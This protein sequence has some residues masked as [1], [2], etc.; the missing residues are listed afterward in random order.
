[1]PINRLLASATLG[2]SLLIAIAAGPSVAGATPRPSVAAPPSFPNAPS[3]QQGARWLASQLTSGGFVASSTPGQPDLVATANTVLALASAGVD[4]PAA[5]AALVYLETHINQYVTVSGSD[6]PGQL[7]ILILDA[8][9]LGIDP[10]SFGG[11]DLVARLLATEQLSGPNAGLFGIQD[12]SF[13]GAFR[14]GLSLAALAAAGVTGQTLAD[15]WLTGQQCPDG[16]WTSLITL[17]NPCS[18]DPASFSGPDTNSTALAIQGLEAQHALDPTHAASA[19]AFLGGGQDSDGGWSFFP[20]TVTTPGSTDPDSTAL[21]VQALVALGQSPL[22]SQ[23]AKGSSTPVSSLLGFQIGSGA[24]SGAF[25]FTGSTT[26]N[27]LATYQAVPALAG[28]A[29]PLVAN[30]GGKGYW[31]ASSDGGIFNYGNAAFLGSHGSSPLNK[32]IVGL[33]ATPDGKGYWLAAS[34]GGIFNYGNA[35]FAGSH[36]GSPLNKPIVGMA[37]TPDG[38]GYWLVASDGG[39]FAY[40]D[41]AFQGSHGGSPLNKPIVGMAA[42]PSGLGYWLVAS[43]GGIFAYGDAVFQGSHGGSPL[44]KPVVGLAA[45]PDGMGYWLAASDGGIFAY[46][47]AAFLGSHGGSPLNKPVVGIGAT[48]SGLGY[49]LVASDGG[50]L[51]YGDAIFAGSHGSSPLNNPIVGIASTSTLAGT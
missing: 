46:G 12:A 26:P 32:P 18:G 42:T 43:D 9:A 10:R 16:G 17:L 24:G 31:L 51:N 6:G 49:W 14:Q 3:A 20:N 30:S 28:V 19:L 13:D 27:L 21:V 33:A 47:D 39:I 50:I 11:S 38:M 1:M 44:N 4:L 34:D 15:A 36:G 22:A 8:H 23:F 41:A 5:N 7:S 35:L 37:A 48:P 2:V 40:G 45:T 29:I 25:F